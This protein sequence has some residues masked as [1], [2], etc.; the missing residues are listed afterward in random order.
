MADILG[1]TRG[2]CIPSMHGARVGVGRL[3][4]EPR[5]RPGTSWHNHDWPWGRGWLQWLIVALSRQL[6]LRLVDR[7]DSPGPEVAEVL[8]GK[9]FSRLQVRLGIRLAYPSGA[10]FKLFGVCSEEIE[11]EFQNVFVFVVSRH[12]E[13]PAM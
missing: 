6:T 7:S 12:L 8:M 10:A 13:I 2:T 11:P 3:W 9:P 1:T 4:P 5:W